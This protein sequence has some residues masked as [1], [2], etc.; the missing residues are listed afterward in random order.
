VAVGATAIMALAARAA[1]RSYGSARGKPIAAVPAGCR[2]EHAGGVVPRARGGSGSGAAR[3]RRPCRL[4]IS[5]PPTCMMSDRRCWRAGDAGGR[6]RPS[7]GIGMHG[8]PRARL[9]FSAVK[10]QAGDRTT[11][12]WEYP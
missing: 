4:T 7:V 6:P 9:G 10:R 3:C 5:I 2:R 11:M 12:G 8:P 1:Q